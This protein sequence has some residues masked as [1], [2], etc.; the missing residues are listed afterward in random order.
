M[1]EV[2][3]K[4]TRE[5]VEKHLPKNHSVLQYR[6]RSYYKGYKLVPCQ[7]VKGNRYYGAVFGPDNK[8]IFHSYDSRTSGTY[9]WRATQQARIKIREL[10]LPDVSAS[11][12]PV[13]E[14]LDATGMEIKLDLTQRGVKGKPTVYIDK[15]RSLA[16]AYNKVRFYYYLGSLYVKAKTKQIRFGCQHIPFIRIQEAYAQVS[17]ESGEEYNVIMNN[18]DVATAEYV[19][20]SENFYIGRSLPGSSSNRN[21]LVKKEGHKLG[22]KLIAKG[23]LKPESGGYRYNSYSIVPPSYHSGHKTGIEKLKYLNELVTGIE[24]ALNE[25]SS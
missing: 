7:N 20:E 24:E 25:Q 11:A 10:N 1:P 19:E 13:S 8:F 12:K 18:N 4:L 23:P 16:V 5:E 22:T 17:G 9:S 2:I 6:D 3:N 15:A 14:R 21:I